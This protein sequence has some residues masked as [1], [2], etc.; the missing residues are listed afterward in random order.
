MFKIKFWFFKRV[1]TDVLWRSKHIAFLSLIN[2]NVRQCDFQNKQNKQRKVKVSTQKGVEKENNQKGRDKE[3]HAASMSLSYTY[4]LPLLNMQCIV[5]RRNTKSYIE[6]R[7]HKHLVERQC[8]IC[9]YRK[10]RR[11]KAPWLQLCLRYYIWVIY[12]YCIQL[13]RKHTSIEFK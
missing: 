7:T 11:S 3:G 1:S 13:F 8:E 10:M 4:R 2:L 12:L 6:R 9:M 5:K